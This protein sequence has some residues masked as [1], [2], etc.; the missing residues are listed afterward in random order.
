M[1]SFIKESY[2]NNKTFF[3]ALIVLLCCIIFELIVIL[4]LNSFHLTYTIDDSYIH[5]ALAENIWKG[6]YGIN[7]QE[8]SSPSSSILWPF[9]LSPFSNITIG[10]YSPLIINIFSGVGTL[11]LIYILTKT[12][13]YSNTP[14]AKMKKVE[15]LFCILIIPATD[16]IGLIFN[17]MEH[18][19][20]VFFTVLIIWGLTYEI[21]NKR[22]SK[23]L[24]IAIILAPLVRYENLALSLAAL[25]YLFIRGY[26]R[27]SLLTT[28]G[29]VVLIGSF[30]IFLL[31]IGLEPLPLSVI[32]KSSVVSSYGNIGSLVENL[33][34]NIINPR[35]ILLLIGMLFLL[36]L[37]FYGKRSKEEKLLAGCVALSIL[38]HI[39]AGRH[40][41]YLL[42][43]WIAAIIT[44]LY[45]NRE[46]VNKTI[47][48]NSFYKT[49][50]LSC[51]I[52]ISLSYTYIYIIFT[53]P[54][55]SN[56][57]YEQ[58]YQMHRFAVDYYKKPVA[59]N[60]LGY[61]AYKND[62]YVL[63]LWGLA[64]LEALKYRKAKIKS[65]WMDVLSK[66]H[67][68][69]L[70][71]IYDRWFPNIPKS[72]LK[73]GELYLGKEKFSPAE[74]VV[75][76]YVINLPEGKAGKKI[77]GEVSF[78]LREFRKTL[79]KGVKLIMVEDI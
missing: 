74:S 52:L 29:I 61:V 51:L 67:G 16:M 4:I 6:H 31:N 25:I 41:R 44:I 12:I 20:Q 5:L 64:S 43:I 59:V 79:P 58:Q 49:A 10:N 78:L 28:F 46:Q 27:A 8:Y 1:D 53:T 60:D 2:R 22:I 36:Y 55:A 54:L 35:C 19:L 24:V 62:N 48:K 50:I 32:A 76:F 3:I 11:F 45:L 57:I 77:F 68:V 9:I 47:L 37:M 39:L 38:L 21:Q 15:L 65:D 13:F 73:A 23:W 42:Y 40:G 70:A 75:S 17:G 14:D 26:Y 33:K 72:W 18:S 69:Q 66:K 7:L 71:M 34:E 63:D 30:S 56:N